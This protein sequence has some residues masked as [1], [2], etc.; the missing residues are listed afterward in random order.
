MEGLISVI[1][2][3][4]NREAVIKECIESVLSQSYQNLEIILI[5]DGSTDNS[6]NI[7]RDLCEKDN[8]I[9][10]ITSSHLGVSGARNVGLD[11]ATGDYIF[12]LDSDDFIHPML[13]ETLLSPLEDGSAQMSA[14]LVATISQSHWEKGKGRLLSNQEKVVPHIHSNIDTIN[15]VFKEQT[16]FSVLGGVMIKRSLIGDTRFN[17]ELYIGED[18]YFIYE[19]LIKGA[20]TAWLNQR[21]YLARWHTNNISQNYDYS[22]FWTRFYRRVLVWRSEETLSRKENANQQKSESLGCFLRCYA[23][24]KDNKNEIKKMKD[25]LKEYR[26]EI[27]CSLPF[28]KKVIYYLTVYFTPLYVKLKKVAKK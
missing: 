20:D 18:F 14:T 8:R 16:P 4:Y 9:K 6:Q 3:V 28:G 19:N 13:L 21:W 27:T 7:C 15:S 26:K 11:A 10:L 2:P 1:V 24:S 22:A 12:F 25:T 5:D 23:N 17:T